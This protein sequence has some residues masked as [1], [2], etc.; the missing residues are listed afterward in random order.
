MGYIPELIDY[1]LRKGMDGI[2]A[3]EGGIFFVDRDNQELVLRLAFGRGDGKSREGHRLKLGEGIAGRTASEDRTIVIHEVQ[4]K[5][6]LNYVAGKKE[7]SILCVPLKSGVKLIGV[8]YLATDMHHD[9]NEEGISSWTAAAET[10]V[11][12]LILED[13]YAGRNDSVEADYINRTRSNLLMLV[14]HEIRAPLTV[15]KE[16]ISLIC[17]GIITEKLKD[18]ERAN[19]LE[20]LRHEVDRLSRLLQNLAGLAKMDLGKTDLIRKSMNIEVL[21]NDVVELMSKLANKRR[22]EIIKDVPS[23]LP[24]VPADQD[25]VMQVIV[26]LVSNAIKFSHQDGRII[27]K[28]WMEEGSLKICV[29]DNGMG[30]PR[31]ELPRIFNK[32]YSLDTSSNRSS[33]GIGLGLYIAR[34]IIDSH[35]GKIW[36]ESEMGKGSRFFFTLPQKSE[37]CKASD[38]KENPRSR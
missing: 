24:E 6:S 12:L 34:A 18:G 7:K 29:E 31:E 23:G 5:S 25:K 37:L 14:T 10:A 36:A 28:A 8:G 1:V 26:N 11:Q 20:A 17:D 32:L 16:G 38:E 35:G 30:I 33:D 15:I 13:I 3:N 9:F 19:F 21:L 27:I 4:E 22:I 2:T